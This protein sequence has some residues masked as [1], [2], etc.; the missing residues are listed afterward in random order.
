[1]ANNSPLSS[2]I[3]CRK[4]MES[5]PNIIVVNDH[6]VTYQ[7]FYL[8]SISDIEAP[9]ISGCPSA[10]SGPTDLGNATRVVS[11]TEPT[12]SDNSGTQT[13]TSTHD[14]GNPFPIGTTMVTYTS[15]DDAGNDDTCKFNIVVHGE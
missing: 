10:Q 11:W 7:H 9:V 13:L 4:P 6:N 2:P 8:F 3:P 14:P 12:A 5:K 1:M 15:I